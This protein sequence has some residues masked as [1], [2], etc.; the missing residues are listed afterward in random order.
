MGHYRIPTIMPTL[1]R[2][3]HTAAIHAAAIN[4]LVSRT[5]N[6]KFDNQIVNMLRTSIGNQPFGW[7]AHIFT[8][9]IWGRD[10]QGCD[11]A[12]QSGTQFSTLRYL[13]ED[14]A[15]YPSFRITQS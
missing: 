8:P 2:G 12:L 6:L 10:A 7:Q 9:H 15:L 11:T 1:G 13:Q 14:A 4:L 3:M 5:G